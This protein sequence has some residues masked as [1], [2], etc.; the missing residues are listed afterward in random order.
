M[1]PRGIRVGGPARVTRAPIAE[2]ASAQERAT[3]LWRT[4]P[5]IQIAL[6]L[7]VAEAPAQGEDVQQGLARMLVLSVAGVDHR[8]VGP[9]A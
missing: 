1:I 5:T 2:K 4:S 9:A 7:E 3:R 8:R 6:A